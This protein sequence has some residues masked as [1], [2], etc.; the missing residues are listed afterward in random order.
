MPAPIV[1]V[2]DEAD[3]S[4]RTAAMLQAAGYDAISLPDSMAA[5]DAMEGAVR[6]E[7]LVTC[8]DHGAGKPNGVALA[9][10]ARYKRPG[11][12]I[13][14]VGAAEFAQHTDGLGVFIPDPVTAEDV[15]NAVVRALEGD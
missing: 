11:I 6:V 8:V 4:E 2:L 15:T 12:R 5:L 9:R 3:A 13:L 7:V 1:I 14:F 10:M